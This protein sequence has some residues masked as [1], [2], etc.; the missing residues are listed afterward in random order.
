MTSPTL[1]SLYVYI[2]DTSDIAM[3]TTLCLYCLQPLFCLHSWYIQHCNYIVTTLPT[4]SSLLSTSTMPLM[5]KCRQHRKYIMTSP[6]L[7]PFLSTPSIRWCQQHC[8]NIPLFPYIISPFFCLTFFCRFCGHCDVENIMTYILSPFCI[9][10]VV[11]GRI[12]AV[13]NLR[14][15]KINIQSRDVGPIEIIGSDWNYVQHLC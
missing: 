11:I 4:S 1:S 12:C 5:S 6:S 7:S 8:D 10:L 3:S 2:V 9:H 13:N 15:F 14:I